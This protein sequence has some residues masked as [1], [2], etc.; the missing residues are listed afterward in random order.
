MHGTPRDRGLE[1]TYFA[2]KV[3]LDPDLETGYEKPDQRFAMMEVHG[4]IQR[5]G[6]CRR[7]TGRAIRRGDPGAR[8]GQPGV[9]VLE[10]NH[11]I[12]SPIRTSKEAASS[13]RWRRWGFPRA[14]TIRSHGSVFCPRALRRFSS[15]RF[16]DCAS[17]TCA[18]R[19]SIWRNGRSGQERGFGWPRASKRRSWKTARC[20]AYAAAWAKYARN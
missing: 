4:L 13:R 14:C 1:F 9:T 5:S 12:G 18:E 19:F 3:A 11:E 7:G 8:G 15:I 16:R 6:H 17:W 10:Q 2:A 20:A